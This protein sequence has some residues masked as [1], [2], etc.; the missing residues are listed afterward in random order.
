M[1]STSAHPSICKYFKPFYNKVFA[2]AADTVL[3]PPKISL[4]QY[5]RRLHILRFHTA[6]SI[7]IGSRR[8]SAPNL[9][10]LP[11]AKNQHTEP[12]LLN[13]WMDRFSVGHS[14]MI[15]IGFGSGLPQRFFSFLSKLLVPHLTINLLQSDLYP[16]SCFWYIISIHSHCWFLHRNPLYLTTENSFFLLQLYKVEHKT[17][18]QWLCTSQTCFPWAGPKGL[19]IQTAI[20]H[21]LTG[22]GRARSQRTCRERGAW[23]PGNSPSCLPEVSSTF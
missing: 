12:K 3:F 13:F 15:S 11:A 19:S 20:C 2:S 6:L 16:H 5:N 8:Y 23:C 4:C 21:S 22:Q 18:R 17:A 1:A 10:A 7:P 14:A 9:P